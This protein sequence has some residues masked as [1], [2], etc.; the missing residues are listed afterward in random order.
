M[1][2]ENDTVNEEIVK[3][4]EKKPKQAESDASSEAVETIE[5]YTNSF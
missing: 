4:E 1:Q 5:Y 3:V 2:I